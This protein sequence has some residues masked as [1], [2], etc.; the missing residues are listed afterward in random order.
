MK[1][2]LEMLAVIQAAEGDICK[3]KL[4][5]NWKIAIEN[6]MCTSDLGT[7]QKLPYCK[8]TDRTII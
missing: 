5:G 6:D 2:V 8:L 3:L 1:L 7:R 4:K